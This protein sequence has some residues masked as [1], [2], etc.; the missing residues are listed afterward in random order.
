M[1]RP[2]FE[3]P[4]YVGEKLFAS[5]S[6]EY[7]PTIFIVYSAGKKQQHTKSFVLDPKQ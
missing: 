6:V 7:W 5:E 2:T 1:S 3:V 4:Q